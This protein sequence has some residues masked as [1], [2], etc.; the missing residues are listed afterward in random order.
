M[1][2]CGSD[3]NS[4]VGT[5]GW[6]IAARYKNAFRA[7]GSQLEQYAQLLNAAEIN[8]S[9]HRHHRRQTYER[10]ASCVPADFRFSV[11]VPRA[12][13]HEGRLT[14]APEVLERFLE[15]VGGLGIKLG[16][17]LVQLPP[18]L[19]FDARV[20]G[21]FLRGLR[22][23]IGV[24]LACEPRHASWG[25][26]RADD[27]LVDC[28]V[29]R[30]AADPAPWP[31]ADAPGGWRGLAYFRWHGQPRKYY[32]D[33]DEDRLAHLRQQLDAAAEEG[34]RERWSIFDNTASGCALGNAL[35]VRSALA[36]AAI[37][38]TM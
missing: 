34:A 12:L 37:R 22:R 4:Y 6:S 24:A 11:K 1:S 20:V 33:Y 17:L 7:G 3:R 15:E 28:A 13:T 31:G 2:R 27:L 16:A 5:A 29:T 35:A 9:F 38:L 14:L 19:S 8:S 32:S 25:T 30:V 10:W 21:R 26:Q 18:S 36:G 23:R